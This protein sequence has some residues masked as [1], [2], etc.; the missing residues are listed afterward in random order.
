MSWQELE[1]LTVTAMK[2]YENFM[3][4]WYLIIFVAMAFGLTNTMLMAVFERTRELGLFQALGMRPRFIV[5][6]VMIE[7]FILLAIGIVVG[8][9]TGVFT[10]NVIFADGIDLSAF[11]RG[12]EQFTMASTM[13]FTLRAKDIV[14]INLLVIVLGLLASLYPAIKAARF[15]PVEAIART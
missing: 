1:P 2:L 15:V 14:T 3:I 8:N 12:M 7:S 11:S 5:G 10:T 4:I 6:Q 9:L 13:Y